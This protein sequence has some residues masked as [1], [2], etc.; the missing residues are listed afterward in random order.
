MSDAWAV[1]IRAAVQAGQVDM[2]AASSGVVTATVLG[3]GTMV[4][5]T[6]NVHDEQ[7][8]DFFQHLEHR[9][10]AGGNAG[11]V[12]FKLGHEDTGFGAN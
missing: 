2:S 4:W 3:C 5:T 10:D 1:T 8:Q 12:D 11:K 7:G 9:R 6:Q